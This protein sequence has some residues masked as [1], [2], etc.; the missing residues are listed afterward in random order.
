MTDWRCS[1]RN[2]LFSTSRALMRA[3]VLELLLASMFWCVGE[4][5]ARDNDEDDEE[6]VSEGVKR[7][8]E[9]GGETRLDDITGTVVCVSE[10][11]GTFWLSV[12][13]DNNTSSRS[14]SRAGLLSG[15][16]WTSR[17]DCCGSCKNASRLKSSTVGGAERLS[18]TCVET[19]VLT[20]RSRIS[21]RGFFREVKEG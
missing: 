20:V 16:D 21:S 12:F 14:L 7:N 2:M 18:L 9:E 15:V 10:V 1:P 6:G 3:S 17:C 11:G 8:A 19:A 4:R 5:E 13:K